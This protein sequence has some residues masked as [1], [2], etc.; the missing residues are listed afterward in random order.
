MFAAVGDHHQIAP[1]LVYY[2]V[3]QFIAET[4]FYIVRLARK[5]LKDFCLLDCQA[6]VAEKVLSFAFLLERS[7]NPLHPVNAVIAELLSIVGVEIQIAAIPIEGKGTDN[8]LLSVVGVLL[9][10][11]RAQMEI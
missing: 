10:A 4:H 3:G 9:F 5:H 11:V 1:E 7:G 6:F 2:G 8:D